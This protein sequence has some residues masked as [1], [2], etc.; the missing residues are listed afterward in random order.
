MFQRHSLCVE[1]DQTWCKLI[2]TFLFSTF[3]LADWSILCLLSLPGEVYALKKMTSLGLVKEK[4]GLEKISL[5]STVTVQ[6]EKC[7]TN[8]L[9]HTEILK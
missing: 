8:I 4:S 9:Y 6:T 7:C 5:F 1:V 2:F 3:S